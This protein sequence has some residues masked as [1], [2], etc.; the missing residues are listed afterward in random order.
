[1]PEE[2]SIKKASLLEK[3][4]GVARWKQL[5][6]AFTVQTSTKQLP[7]V[8]YADRSFSNCNFA[9]DGTVLMGEHMLG[10]GSNYPSWGPGGSVDKVGTAL[11]RI[12][13]ED[14]FGYG[15]IFRFTLDGEL[16][17]E[18]ENESHGGMMGFL[19]TTTASLSAD[20]KT[21]LYSSETGPRVMLY[22]LDG[23]QQLPDFQTFEPRAGMVLTQTY[24]P[25]GTV[26]MLKAVSREDF[27]LQHLTADAEE[28]K[29]WELPEAGWA[30]ISP[31]SD[32]NIVMLGN[33]FGGI[34]AKF[35]LTKGEIVA[36]TTVDTKRSLA[37][38]AEY[39]G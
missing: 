8:K 12:P 19:G 13:G 15:H 25:D 20:G 34:V 6:S 27:V 31:T 4:L 14:M 16:V 37:G 9:P 28:I 1:M 29:T 5:R 24:R 21:M 39:A 35:D 17:K 32:E 10:D 23:D 38:I 11:A 2:Q 36:Q 3:F 26:L 22:D 30:I 7:E 33:F 18:Y